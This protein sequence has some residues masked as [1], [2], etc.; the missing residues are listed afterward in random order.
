M[1]YYMLVETIEKQIFLINLENMDIADVMFAQEDQG[2]DYD[3]KL[4]DSIH[5]K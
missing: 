4:E 1:E 5:L 3:E 2:E